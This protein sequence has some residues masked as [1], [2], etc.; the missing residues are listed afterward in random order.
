MLR[1]F[2]VLWMVTAPSLVGQQAAGSGSG[3]EPA[4]P[5]QQA[6]PV[7]PSMVPLHSAPGEAAADGLWAAGPRYKASFH[8][9]FTFYPWIPDQQVTRGFRWQTESVRLGAHTRPAGVAALVHG[10]WRCELRRDALVET[11]DVSEHGV[12][13]SF[14]IETRPATPGPIVVTGRIETPFACAVHAAA[15]A[16]LVFVAPEGVGGVRYGAASVVDRAGNSAPVRTAFDGERITLEVD[17]DFV[18]HATFPITIDP[19]TAEV[20]VATASIPITDTSITAGSIAGNK[21]VLACYVREFSATDYDV[22]ALLLDDAQVGFGTLVYSELSAV[23]STTK[24]AAA[25]VNTTQTWAIAVQRDEAGQPSTCYVYR[26]AQ[27]SLVINSGVT[28]LLP[29]QPSSRRN[30]AIGGSVGLSTYVLMVFEDSPAFGLTRVR[31]SLF[32]T[33]TNTFTGNF[34]LHGTVVPTTNCRQPY[35]VRTVGGLDPWRVTWSEDSGNGTDYLIRINI[36]DGSGVTSLPRT[37]A[38]STDAREPRIDGS[39]GRYLMT[40]LDT[41]AS[42]NGQMHVRRLDYSSTG[43]VSNIHDHVLATA[44]QVPLQTISNGDL[45]YDLVTQSHWAVTWRR[46]Q[47]LLLPAT[48]TAYVARFGY[49]GGITESFSLHAA[50][51]EGVANPSVAFD[52]YPLGGEAEGFVVTYSTATATNP[53]YFRRYS[54]TP[55]SGMLYG[56]SCRSNTM[57]DGHPPYAGSEFYRVAIFG[58]PASTVALAVFGTSPTDVPLDTIGAPGCHLLVDP[59]VV[60]TEFADATG[61]AQA[62]VSLPDDPVFVGNLYLQWAWFEPGANALGFVFGRGAEIHVQ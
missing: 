13:Q 28:T 59:I 33:Q 22:T 17:A 15:C 35:V 61:L 40:W 7:M 9:G 55:P 20:V 62:T 43:V 21:R 38:T 32:D 58:L 57:G 23:Y 27:A 42:T 18:S 24:V 8:D 36:V 11:Y 4:V 19:L 46:T 25:E 30:P 31:G 14:V 2:C 34:D 44:L 10:D 41:P 12:E 37:M 29:A 51:N 56:T 45:G 3:L 26:H 49:T 52:G 6:V 53:A 1:S 39:A 47:L 54:Y 60:M 48:T 16:E 50:N 5:E